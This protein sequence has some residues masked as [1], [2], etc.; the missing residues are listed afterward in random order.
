MNNA[1]K[2]SKNGLCHLHSRNLHVRIIEIVQQ[3]DAIVP[4]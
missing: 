1:E 3:Y 2:N 4:M